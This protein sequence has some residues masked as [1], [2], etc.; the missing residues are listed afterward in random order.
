[1]RTKSL[2]LLLSFFVLVSAADALGNAV[3]GP[4][5]GFSLYSI[6]SSGQVSDCATAWIL[7]NDAPYSSPFPI[8]QNVSAGS[9][10]NQNRWVI[11]EIAFPDQGGGFFM[12]GGSPDLF[13][14][15][16]WVGNSQLNIQFLKGQFELEDEFD[17]E[18]FLLDIHEAPE[19]SSAAL[20][21]VGFV[22]F[23]SRQMRKRSVV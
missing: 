5:A 14:P 9:T 18:H 19:P 2:F 4:Y 16:L 13:G 17:Y 6:S 11:D 3:A 23:I 7:P 20:L 8:Y 1:M 12:N 15:V 22:I 10:C 21:S